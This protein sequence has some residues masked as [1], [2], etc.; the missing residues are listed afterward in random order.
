M[1]ILTPM[2]R[3]YQRIKENH[4]DAIL[5]YRLGDFYEMFNDDAKIASKILEITLTSREAGQ[6]QKVPLAGVPHHSAAS[7]ISRLIKEGFKVAVCEQVEDPKTAKGVVKREVVRVITPGTVLESGM[8]EDSM[9]NFLMALSFSQHSAGMAFIDISTGEFQCA[10]FK[11][12]NKFAKLNNEISRLNPSECVLPA[13]LKEE[14]EGNFQRNFPNIFLTYLNDWE[15]DRENAYEK[16]IKHFNTNSLK[17]F[18]ISDDRHDA[19]SSAGALFS[20]VLE[21]Q[22][23][24]LNQISRLKEYNVSDYMVLDSSTQKNLEIGN[25]LDILDRTRTSMGGRKLRFWVT[26]PLIKEDLINGRLDAVEELLKSNIERDSLQKSISNIYDIERIAGRL[27]NINIV[28]PRDLISLKESLKIICDLPDKLKRFSSGLL[29]NAKTK[30]EENNSVGQKIIGIIEESINNDPPFLKGERG[31]LKEGKII[32]K[33]YNKE[34]DEL[35]EIVASGKDWVISYESKERERSKIKSLKVRFN[36]IF[37]YYIEVSN[38]S[39]P[40]IPPDYIRKQT[41]ANCERYITPELK[42]YES[43]I[44]GAEEKIVNLE[45]EIFKKVCGLIIPETVVVQTL[46]DIAGELDVLAGLA[47][48]AYLNNYVRPKFSKDKKMIIKKGRHPVVEKIINLE[49]F[50]PNDT[51]MDTETD[52]ILIITGPNMAG[53]STYIRQVAL[54]TLM[55]HCG[56]FVPAE[57]AEI[58]LTDRIFTRIGAMDNLSKGESTFLV[59]MNETANIL[60]NA[61][62]KSLIILDEVGRGTSTFDGLS[63][64][65]AVVEFLHFNK[66]VKARTLFAT[67]YHEL[68]ELSLLLPGVKNYNVAVREWNDEVVFLHQIVPGGADKSYGIH[69]AQIAGLPKEV[70]TRAKEILFELEKNNMVCHSERSEESVVGAQF[71]APRNQGVINHAPTGERFLPSVEMTDR[72]VEMTDR[73]VEMTNDAVEMTQLIEKIKSLDIKNLTPLDALN[74]LSSIQEDL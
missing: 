40:Q 18:G 7:Y 64:A 28:T 74:F 10:E 42:D 25:L 47:L 16:L 19:I 54:I 59:E 1:E 23:S 21:N 50:I 5:L 48:S 29:K 36:R 41:L 55:A 52:Q 4:K 62:E 27:N 15:Y 69:V 14:L 32:K 63:I 33:G 66:H 20:Y 12:E 57:E 45:M 6:G 72:S 37:G 22:K 58:G 71:I 3:Q 61:T 67:H 65:W 31:G 13:K 56:S 26:H 44:L 43:K 8:L 68:I 9:N 73:S 34:L 70:L 2:M 24:N 30:I 35:L 11:G 17:G 49:K 53:K 38:P 60:N 39:L 51:L 46:A